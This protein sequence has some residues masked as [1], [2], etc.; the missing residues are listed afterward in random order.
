MGAI[1]VSLGRLCACRHTDAL[2]RRWPNANEIQIL[3]YTLIL[4]PLGVLPWILGYAGPIYGAVAAVA[5]A[6]FLALALRLRGEQRGFTA[7]KQLFGFSILYL[8]VVFAALLVDHM[9]PVLFGHL[10]A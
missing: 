6:A 1:A 10:A 5:G 9:S 3:V 7:C 2:G 8:F 4:A